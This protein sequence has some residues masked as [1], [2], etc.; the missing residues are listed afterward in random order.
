LRCNWDA[1]KK[2][3]L[4][5]EDRETNRQ[6]LLSEIKATCEAEHEDRQRERQKKLECRNDLLGQMDYDRRRKEDD[7]EEELRMRQRQTEAEK[8][9]DEETK[10][11]LANPIHLKWNPKRKQL[12]DEIKIP[13]S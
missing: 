10:Y 2:T 1:A 7:R 9:H 3:M 6:M 8:L 4:T 12:P 5:K 11:L 13:C